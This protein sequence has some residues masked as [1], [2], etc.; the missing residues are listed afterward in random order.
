MKENVL[1]NETKTWGK[2]VLT[3]EG[4]EERV[5]RCL[6]KGLVDSLT[7]HRQLPRRL[8]LPRPRHLPHQ[9]GG[10]YPAPRRYLLHHNVG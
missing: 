1:L 3:D 10:S 2:G 5:L 4:D 7:L 6:T 8:A 9:P